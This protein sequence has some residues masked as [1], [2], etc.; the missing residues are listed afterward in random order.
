MQ[1][2]VSLL[3]REGR[4]QNARL[5]REVFCL[6]LGRGFVRPTWGKPALSGATR[7]RLSHRRRR[8]PAFPGRH[9]Q[10]LRDRGLRRR[11][12]DARVCVKP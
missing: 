12:S 11:P 5:E 2:V 8:H 7:N 6:A 9:D 4:L 10:R 3:E 1:L